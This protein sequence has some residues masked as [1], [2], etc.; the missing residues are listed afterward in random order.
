MKLGE[1]NKRDKKSGKE[2]GGSP[3][4]EMSAGDG[5]DGATVFSMEKF[6]T[7][8]Q[9]YNYTQEYIYNFIH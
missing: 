2:I 1:E 4:Y 7:H 9:I 3:L 6:A 5:V 8:E